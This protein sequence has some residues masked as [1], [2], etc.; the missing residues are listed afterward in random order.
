MAGSSELGVGF[1]V[2]IKIRHR[3]SL[4]ALERVIGFWCDSLERVIG[5]GRVS[6][7]RVT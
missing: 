7:E 5:L 1:S 6:L 4:D 3:I 2:K